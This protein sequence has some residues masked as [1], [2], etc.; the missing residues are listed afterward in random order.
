MVE[1]IEGHAEDAMII[2]FKALEML[3]KYPDFTFILDQA[4]AVKPFWK[5]FPEKREKLKSYV[6][7]GRIEVVGATYAAPDLNIPTGEALVRQF[8]YGKN[9]CK[10]SWVLRWKWAGR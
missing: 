10:T 9:F 8:I 5:A 4:L 2:I 6:A 3:D 7:A 1:T